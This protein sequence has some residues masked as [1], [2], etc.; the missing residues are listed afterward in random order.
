M[1]ENSIELAKTQV[2]GASPGAA[3]SGA[4]ASIG[5]SASP[6][7]GT[8]SASPRAAASGASGASGSSAAP[9]TERAS[10]TR[11]RD[12]LERGDTVD[13]YVILGSLGAGGMG[14][15]YAAYDPELDRRVALKLLKSSR[16]GDEARARL[17]REAQAMARL[18]HPN[19]VAVYDVG[20]IGERV[21]TAMELVEGRTFAALL[22]AGRPS[23]REALDIA[24]A[25]G[26]GLQAAH[27]AGLIH[28]DIKP[29]NVMIGVDGR[30]R[31]VDFGLAREDGGTASRPVSVDLRD[32]SIE[33]SSR[34]GSGSKDILRTDITH[35]HSLV[36]TPAYMAPEQFVGG[37]I[38][39]RTDVFAWCVT[40][41][42]AIYGERPFHGDGLGSLVI[43]VS[44]GKIRPPP[45]GVAAPTWIRRILER[46]LRPD[47]VARWPSMAAILEAIERG[48]RRGR[49]RWAFAGAG[50]LALALVGTVTG[51]ALVRERKEARCEAAGAS[52]TRI[53]DADAATAIEGT[54]AASPWKGASA[55]WARVR[56]RIDEYAGRWGDARRALCVDTT[57]RGALAVDEAA[58]RESCLDERRKNLAA[59]LT[60]LRDADTETVLHAVPMAMRL[61]SIAS[62]ADALD[63]VYFRALG[64][65]SHLGA[66]ARRVRKSLFLERMTRASALQWAGKYREASTAME[67][68]LPE[69]EGDERRAERAALLINVGTIK[70]DVG[71]FDGAIEAMKRGAALAVSI[72]LDEQARRASAQLCAIVGLELGHPDDGQVWCDLSAAWIDHM[73]VDTSLSRAEHLTT[74]STLQLARGRHAE[75]L[76]AIEEALAIERRVLVAD[77]P[78]IAGALNRYGVIHEELAQFPEAEAAYAEAL[79]ITVAAYGPEHPEVAPVEEN[80]GNVQWARGDLEGALGH[81]RRAL[82]IRL[83]VETDPISI[84]N[85][86]INIGNIDFSRG[87]YRAAAAS[88]ETALRAF[89]ETVGDESPRLGFSLVNLGAVHTV[90]RELDEAEGYLARALKI[91]ERSLGREHSDVAFV[92]NNLGDVAKLRGNDTRALA[93][94]DEA[95]AIWERTLGPEHPYLAFALLGRAE[96]RLRARPAAARDDLSRALK[97]RETEA[98]PAGIAEV[99]TLLGLAEL[100]L[101]EVDQ[102]IARE[103]RARELAAGPDVQPEIRAVAAFALARALAAGRRDLPAARD[104]AREA[105]DLYVGEGLP[106]ERE[107]AEI[108][109]WLAAHR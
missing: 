82:A 41:W 16:G 5:S 101:G 84:A 102:A 27:A 92:L 44:T 71:D 109:A 31:V 29:E 51:R 46:G 32:L 30:V 11:R 55:S 106:R 2:G 57:I 103:T 6:G 90:L 7:G 93:Y 68:L 23:W 60:V 34:I 80:L 67:A 79:R 26:V 49:R 13:R 40:T 54:F 86:R 36:G 83:E 28:R 24:V 61:P 87:D 50:A 78:V 105:R 96:I 98:N 10:S 64:G 62:C 1:S 104:L 14:V 8:S 48:R 95:A 25:V 81:H 63:R 45:A 89:E 33:T 35:D 42:E 108:D 94:Y 65:G 21:W 73:T 39:V 52:I 66:F 4:T 85:S 70:R 47:P 59:V 77:D 75:A 15:V 12:R 76:A 9:S 22:A 43:Q 107:I 74:V 88:Y 37:S 91:R 38:D 100:A 99:L 18:Q 19:V 17:L 97:I 72:G 56:D 58:A 53:W 20:M 3:M 69:V